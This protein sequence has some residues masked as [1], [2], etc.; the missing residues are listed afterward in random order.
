MRLK[1]RP[2]GGNGTGSHSESARGLMPATRQPSCA[3]H[4]PSTGHDGAC[5]YRCREQCRPHTSPS[6]PRK[7]V[8]WYSG[9]VK[10]TLDL[11]DDLVRTIKLRAVREDRKLKDL[12]AELLRRGLEGDPGQPASPP[13][14][15]QLPL[16]RG[17]H[18]A[19]PEEEM[20]P[21]RVAA[22]LLDEEVRGLI[23]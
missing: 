20:T 17:G 12:I 14:R 10:T 4:L 2:A 11:P 6:W 22:V 23:R 21:D 7:L 1:R 13:H 3:A 5:R 18:P 15:V 8:F 9:E 16:I 19:V